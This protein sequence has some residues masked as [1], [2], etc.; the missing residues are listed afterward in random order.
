MMQTRR[1]LVIATSALVTAGIT[2]RA[3]A[4]DANIVDYLVVQTAKGL[5]FEKATNTLSLVGVSPI[6]LFF[7]DRPERVAGNEDQRVH[8]ILEPG[9]R[10]LCQG[11]GPAD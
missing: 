5:T 4:D 11:T 3:L 7:A 1:N 10:Q 2:T 8:S 9:Q 6:T